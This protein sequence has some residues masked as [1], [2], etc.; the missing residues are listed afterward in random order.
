MAIALVLGATGL[1]GRELTKLLLHHQQFSEVHVFVRRRT[2]LHSPM[3]YEHV[4]AFDRPEQWR[5][6]VKGDVLFSAMGT[7]LK[8]AGSKEA[9]Y[10]VDY[11][12]Q[13]QFAQAAAQN[14]V[15]RYVL[16]SAANA[17]LNSLFFYSRMKAELERDVLRLP[18][19]HTSILQPGLLA[20]DRQEKRT[21]EGLAL[22]LSGLL[23]HIPGLGMLKSI[24]GESVAKAMI[25]AATRQ[26][27]AKRIYN[28]QE[29]FL[30]AQ[31]YRNQ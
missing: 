20:G 9:Q 11:T 1:V 7:T 4:V 24:P 27:E 31:H 26:K 25:Q 18:F 29:L 5:D 12:Y 17:A 6:E 28:M 16:V 23:Q 2:G 22:K 19:E 15:S 3:L 14:S 13:Y 30:L 8:A 10:K 21:G